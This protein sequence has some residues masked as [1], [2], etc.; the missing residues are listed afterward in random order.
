MTYTVVWIYT[1]RK[2]VVERGRCEFETLARAETYVHNVRTY[3]G[4][5][6]WDARIV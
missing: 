4:F 5:K 1:T 6:N 3:G 2:G